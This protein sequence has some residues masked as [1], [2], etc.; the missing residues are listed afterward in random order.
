MVVRVGI[1][2]RVGLRLGFGLG[3][4]LWQRVIVL[5]QTPKRRTVQ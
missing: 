5:G 4:W 1:G 3:E 2:L